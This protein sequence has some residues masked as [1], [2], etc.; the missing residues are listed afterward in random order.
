MQVTFDNPAWATFVAGIAKD[1][2][3]SLGVDFA[4]SKPKVE[5]YKLLVYEAGSQ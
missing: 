4:V 3:A 1:A 5:L 2:C